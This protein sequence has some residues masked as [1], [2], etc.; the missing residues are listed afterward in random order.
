MR[1]G[2]RQRAGASRVNILAKVNSKKKDQKKERHGTSHS[3]LTSVGREVAPEF[4]EHSILD[5]ANGPGAHSAVD[6]QSRFQ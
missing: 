6:H 1:R 3:L 5:L 2:P 4:H